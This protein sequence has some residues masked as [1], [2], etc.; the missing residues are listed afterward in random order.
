M[1][2]RTTFPGAAIARNHLLTDAGP[3]TAA[4]D[5]VDQYPAETHST[6]KGLPADIVLLTTYPG[7]SETCQL[8]LR[9]R[10]R[11][12]QQKII[13]S[14]RHGQIELHHPDGSEFRRT[15]ELLEQYRDTP[16]SLADASLVTAAEALGLN[17]VFTY[18]SDFRIYVMR[19]GT[20]LQMYPQD[21][22]QQ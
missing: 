4:A 10:R 7:L 19:N 16:M 12:Q 8:L 20:A 22:I 14:C 1:T 2:C 6:L 17:T 15:L 3:L 9:R 21:F 18:D 5:D 13:E 11:W